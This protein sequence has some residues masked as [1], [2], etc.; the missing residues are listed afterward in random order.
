MNGRL[1]HLNE[2]VL[3]FARKD[4]PLLKQH[5]TMR[6]ALDIIREKG[7][8]DR[9][10]YFYVVDEAD[11]LVGV[12]PTRRLLSAPPEQR[13]GDV[14]IRRVGAVPQAATFL[15]LFGV[16]VLFRFLA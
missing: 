12:L 10:I 5:C 15:E 4:F 2:P 7:I 8:G 6:E 14:M 9:I 3:A 11:R 13:L 16:F 1:E